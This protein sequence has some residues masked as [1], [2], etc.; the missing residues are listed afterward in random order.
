MT[1]REFMHDTNIADGVAGEEIARDTLVF[2][3]RL[4]SS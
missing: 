4:R 2:V 3:C 1:S